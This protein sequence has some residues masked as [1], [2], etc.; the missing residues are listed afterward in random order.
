MLPLWRYLL[1]ILDR[2]RSSSL[3]VHQSYSFEATSVAL[4]SLRLRR[5]STR[6]ARPHRTSQRALFASRGRLRGCLDSARGK[7]T[8][9]GCANILAIVSTAFSSPGR[10]RK[11]E[12]CSQKIG[13]DQGHRL[14]SKRLRML[15]VN[16]EILARLYRATIQTS[17]K[18]GVSPYF[19]DGHGYAQ[20]S[21]L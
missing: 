17:P 15:L 19:C 1:A 5:T 4:A 3:Q 10:G 9:S 8:K 11:F 18:T 12:R 13:V 20:I 14:S 16:A 6:G 2:R 21:H 7:P